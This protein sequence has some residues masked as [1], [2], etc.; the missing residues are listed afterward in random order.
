[1]TQQG[2]RSEHVPRGPATPLPATALAAAFG[3]LPVGVAVIASDGR[4]LVMNEALGAMCGLGPGESGPTRAGELIE[5]LDIRAVDGTALPDGQSPIE[6]ASAGGR[7]E[8]APM[9]ARA[10]GSAEAMPVACA[11]TPI[12]DGDG[13]AGAVMTVR[14]RQ[15]TTADRADLEESQAALQVLVADRERVQSEERRR[16]ARDLHDDL[17]QSLAALNMRL[18]MAEDALEH[19]PEEARQWLEESQRDVIEAAGATR[20]IIDDLRPQGLY[21]RA[22]VSALHDLVHGF[23]ERTGVA[24]DFAALPAGMPEPPEEVA[25]CIYRIAQ[26]SLTNI[27]K[28]AEA[29][30]VHMRLE[31]TAAGAMHFTV[32]DDGRGLDVP[33]ARYSPRSYGLLGMS[34]RVRAL[35]GEMRV[36]G[37]PGQ[38]TTVEADIPLG[39]AAGGPA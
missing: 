18:G 8:E 37:S 1:M 35:N 24:C 31:R 5:I 28:H 32:A 4:V 6:I 30:S 26:E 15:A 25:D 39:A 14:E 33:T 12:D 29:T 13:W 16:I 22:L 10:V 38:G 20:R 21:H 11:V 36:T 23:T 2:D 17:Q 34:E 27:A 19:D 9:I 7:L 3:V